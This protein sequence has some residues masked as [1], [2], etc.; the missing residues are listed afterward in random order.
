[1]EALGV[2]AVDMSFAGN[3]IPEILA[4]MKRFKSEVMSR[5]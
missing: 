3:T 4:E 2:G 5:L 1:M